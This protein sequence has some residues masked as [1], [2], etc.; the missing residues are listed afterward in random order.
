MIR[1]N[2]QR[3]WTHA[4]EFLQ[5]PGEACWPSVSEWNDLNTTVSGKL[6]HDLP[7]AISCYPGT[8]YNAQQCSYVNAQWSNSS[9][10]SLSPVGYVYPTDETCPPVPAGQTPGSCILGPAPVYTIN[11]TEPAELAA[12]I[13]FA[14]SKNIRLVVRNTGHDLLGR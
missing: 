14:K 9:F 4:S 6:I 11:A 3:S 2:N 10:Q 7:P 8:Y 12:G 13:A 1:H 5:T